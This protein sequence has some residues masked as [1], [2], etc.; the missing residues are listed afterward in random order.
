[1]ST[2]I[3]HSKPFVD[4][5]DISAVVRILKSNYVGTGDEVKELECSFASY[6]QRKYAIAVN[7]GSFALKLSLL[8]LN[9][10]RKGEIATSVY[11]CPA[12]V[13]VILE[14]GYKPRFID[15]GK[16]DVNIDVTA[17]VSHIKSDRKVLAVIIPYAGGYAA[18]IGLILGE[19]VPVIEDCAAS[20][21]STVSNKQ[22]GNRGI[23]SVF[24]FA[25][26][27]MIT[28]G[29]GGMVV[30]DS[31]NCHENIIET[32]KYDYPIKVKGHL[33]A[34]YNCLMNNLQA[35]LI[36]SQLNKL[37]HFIKLRREIA[38]RYDSI[39]SD[40]KNVRLIKPKNNSPSYY[41]YVF[42][43]KERKRIIEGLRAKNID[44][45][46]SFAHFMYKPGSPGR[47]YPNA[48]QLD[49]ELVSLPIYPALSLKEQDRILE[50]L[51]KIL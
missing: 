8:S 7:S 1:M 11:V 25:S 23:L 29:S 30:T 48:R 4:D 36:S 27:K 15:V 14:L 9:L 5:K 38:Q 24:S 33:N 6:S 32:M 2:W 19:R 45:R 28:G 50:T 44:V 31:K 12:V 22:V 18:E 47:D 34:R 39:L 40:K 13:N 46:I 42:L 26:T 35:A 17:L 43:T 20:I 3:S 49:A 37:D 21:G 51:D 41:R 10:K 16:D